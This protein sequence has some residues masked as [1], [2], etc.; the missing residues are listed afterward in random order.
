MYRVT[1]PCLLS[2]DELVEWDRLV[3]WFL[4]WQPPP[5]PYEIMNSLVFDPLRNHEWHRARIEDKPSGQVQRAILV[6]M[7]AHAKQFGG[8][9]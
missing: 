4:T 8:P 5:E 7:R 3:V 6:W 1:V 2:A 9:T